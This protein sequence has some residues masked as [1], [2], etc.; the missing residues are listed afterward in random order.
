MDDRH[1]TG[2]NTITCEVLGDTGESSLRGGVVTDGVSG[3]VLGGLE[4]KTGL[5]RVPSTVLELLEDEDELP[6][7]QLKNKNK[8]N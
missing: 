2:G 5:Q 3:V 6:R 4:E 1:F 7:Q 8:E